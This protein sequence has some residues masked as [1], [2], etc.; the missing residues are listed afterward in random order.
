MVLKKGNSKSLESLLRIVA[1]SLKREP[2]PCPP[3]G[4]KGVEAKGVEAKGVEAKRVEGG[5][6]R[7]QGRTIGD[8]YACAPFLFA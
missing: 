4:A 1:F 6:S 8:N 7:E 5:G 2:R 3:V